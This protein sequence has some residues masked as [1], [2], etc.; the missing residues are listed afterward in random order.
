MVSNPTTLGVDPCQGT[1]TSSTAFTRST[2]T[3]RT[4]NSSSRVVATAVVTVEARLEDT[5]ALTL[6]CRSARSLSGL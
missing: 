2:H 6:R 5:V 1:L 4:T 3:H